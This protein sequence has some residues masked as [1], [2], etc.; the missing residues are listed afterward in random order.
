MI[1]RMTDF[2]MNYSQTVSSR[3]KKINEMKKTFV[4]KLKKHNVKV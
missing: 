3:R 1:R 4:D 2:F